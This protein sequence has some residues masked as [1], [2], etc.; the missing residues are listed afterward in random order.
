MS[1]KYPKQIP[2]TLSKKKL[3][4]RLLEI[5]RNN[6]D[7]LVRVIEVKEDSNRNGNRTVL[8]KHVLENNT[9]LVLAKH[10]RSITKNKKYTKIIR[11]FEI[12]QGVWKNE[13]EINK[14]DIKYTNTGKQIDRFVERTAI[15]KNEKEHETITNIFQR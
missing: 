15:I 1:N 10:L 4:N 8:I 2:Y 13:D 3:E 14:K 12:N 5:R 7:I 6:E 9:E 11:Q